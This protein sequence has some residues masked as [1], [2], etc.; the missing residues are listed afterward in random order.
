M[1][2]IYLYEL[3]QRQNLSNN[4]FN[5]SPYFVSFNE[6]LYFA[7]NINDTGFAFFNLF[8]DPLNLRDIKIHSRTI[9]DQINCEKSEQQRE[10][11][12][13]CFVF[14]SIT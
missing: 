4:V 11:C 10:C 7:S 13:I 6:A 9:L 2:Y 12:L 3:F 8:I 5:S 1:I 14:T